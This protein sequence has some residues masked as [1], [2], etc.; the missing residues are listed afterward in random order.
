MSKKRTRRS[1][2][3]TD[4]PTPSQ[5]NEMRSDIQENDSKKPKIT[6]PHEQVSIGKNNIK[7]TVFEYNPN[8]LFEL[9]L[10]HGVSYL[11]CR[12][13]LGLF[14]FYFLNVFYL[15]FIRICFLFR[16]KFEWWKFCFMA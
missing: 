5:E 13:F 4:E 12:K 3:K 10:T 9:F 1:I 6:H 8:Q 2:V 15:F 16:K 7:K 14:S 11:N